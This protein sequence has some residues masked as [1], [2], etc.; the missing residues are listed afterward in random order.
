MPI[1][2]ND[3]FWS[4][5]ELTLALTRVP[6]VPGLIGRL[7]LFQE[8]RLTTTT[9]RI[10]VRGT[11]LALVPEVPRGSPPTPDVLDR[12]T[13]ASIDIGHF[14]IRSTMLADQVQ[15]VRAFGTTNQLLGVETLR[16]QHLASH[17]SK[18]DLTLEFLR[19]G[20]IRGEV[21]TAVDR[22]TGAPVV[23]RDLYRI[24]DLPRNPEIPFPIRG[25]GA[26]GQEQAV[27]AGQLTTLCNQLGRMVADQVPGGMFTE[28]HIIAGSDFFD[29]FIA[30]PELRAAYIAIDNAPLLRNQLGLEFRFRNVVIEEYRGRVGNVQFVEPDVAYAFPVGQPDMWIELYAPADYLDAVNTVALPRYSKA[31]IFDFDKGLELESQMNCMP[32]CTLPGA[33]FTLRLEDWVP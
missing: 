8:R 29:A 19:L 24:F 23:V 2:L 12:P 32:I 16:N 14:P 17:G 10:E 22:L 6:Y 20:A 11:R 15:N 27:W 26:V 7:G 5:Q 1:D 18:L 3:P 30:H 25:A 9:A 31:R 13:M 28:V 4:V 33:L 21:I